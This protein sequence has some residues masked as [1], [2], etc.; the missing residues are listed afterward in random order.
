MQTETDKET[1]GRTDRQTDARTERQT[2]DGQTQTD[3][4]SQRQTWTITDRYRQTDACRRFLLIQTSLMRLPNFV[5][6]R[7]S[8]LGRA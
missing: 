8:T 7:T 6:Q 1:D 3:T 5:E 2:D 4:D